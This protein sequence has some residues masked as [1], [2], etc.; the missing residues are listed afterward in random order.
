M[1][2]QYTVKVTFPFSDPS[3]YE[4][5]QSKR[6]KYTYFYESLGRDFGDNYDIHVDVY[7]M[8]SYI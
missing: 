3:M 5:Q 1:L 4:F 8:I 7:N 2:K 6:Y